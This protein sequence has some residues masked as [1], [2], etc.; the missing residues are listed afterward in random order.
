MKALVYRT[1]TRKVK[2]GRLMWVTRDAYSPSTCNILNLMKVVSVK[3]FRFMAE[4]W[5]VFAA[6]A[7]K[8]LRSA[9]FDDENYAKVLF[10]KVYSKL[11]CK[12][13]KM[14]VKH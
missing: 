4:L 2:R 7:T 8:I 5:V 13:K 6:V 11:E 12:L 3:V 14:C 1:V 10:S 9:H